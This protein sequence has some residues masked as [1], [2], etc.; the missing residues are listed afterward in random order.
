MHHFCFFF[1]LNLI[2]YLKVK[3]HC[4]PPFSP[5]WSGAHNV[6]Y[7][8]LCLPRVGLTV[9]ATMTGPTVL[10]QAFTKLWDG[11]LSAG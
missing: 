3:I 5:S 7:A 11:H 10:S 8:G 6:D 2:C 9:C 1:L 4:A